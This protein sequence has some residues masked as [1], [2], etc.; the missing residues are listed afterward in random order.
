MADL[1]TLIDRLAAGESLSHGEFVTLIDGRAPETAAYLAEKA[2][3]KRQEIYGNTVFIRGL[4]EVSNICKNDCLYCGI[5]A[6]NP[7]C[8]RYR[9]DDEDILSACAEGYELGFRTFVLQGGEDGH[10]TDGRLTALLTAIKSAHP[11]CAVTLSLGERSRESYEALF[12]A[13]ADRYLLRHETATKSHY[14]KLH[15]AALSFDNRMRCLRDLREIGYQVG[16]GFMVGSPYQTTA[17]IARDLLFIE[18]F[19][20]DMCGIGPFIPHKESIFADFP[21]GTLELTCYLL[22]VIRL[23]HPPS[24]FLPPPLWA[25]STPKGGSWASSRAPTWSCP[26]SPP[27]RCGRSTCSTTTRSRTARNPPRARQSCAAAWRPSDTR[28][29][30]RGAT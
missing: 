12:E 28:W 29:S 10:F 8:D 6:G 13:G 21:A 5:R 23:I 18:E 4:I 11:D 1:F 27:P 3:V 19:K 25:P 20:P 15:P 16:C 9:L 26:I 17:D 22:S 24:S 7:H 30:P 14:E 2:V